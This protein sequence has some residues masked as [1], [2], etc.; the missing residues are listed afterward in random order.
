MAP[1]DVA[2]F[3]ID[4]PVNLAQVT[5]IVLT[6]KPLA[7][8]RVKAVFNARLARFRRFRQRVVERGFPIASPCWEDMP[9]FAIEQQLH[10]VALPAPHD[11]TAL[12]DLI[13]DLAA[14]PL[15]RERPLW[16]AHVVDGIDG[17]SALIIRIHHCLG[18]GTGMMAVVRHLFDATR[19]P[20]VAPPAAAAPASA[21]TARTDGAI[22]FGL[23][24]IATAA[25]DSLARLGAGFDAVMHPQQ[26]LAKAAMIV[27]GVAMLATELL[28]APD[29]KSPLKGKFGMKKR[30]AWSEPVALDDVKAIGVPLGA[31][32]NDVLVAAMTGALRTYL[33]GRD[34]D[35]D[36]TTVRAMVPVDLRPPERVGELGN[37]FGLVILDLP[38]R[39]RSPSQRL[40][41]TKARM[42]ALKRSPEAPAILTLFNLFG[43]GPK[44][45]EDFAVDL[46]GSK[47]SLVMTNVAGPRKTLYLAGVPID[48]LMFW[49]PHPGRQLGMGV[50]ILSYRG[51]ASLAVI[52]DARLVPDP[53]TIARGFNREFARMLA[54]ARRRGARAKTAAASAHA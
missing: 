23:D 14:T 12:A 50:S 52:A 48:R 9:D 25:R 17:G 47:A 4:G 18:D 6:R 11:Q 21:G 15:D 54:A 42:D 24:A 22:A 1:A 40:R 20:P 19:N 30:V 13:S 16:Q 3:H 44:A 33:Q 41:T 38:V 34:V 27:D 29:P 28:K 46:F 5:G 37:E 49:V 35:V 2:W 51:T 39:G 36:R 26:A 10:H 31:K 8:A 45:V 43:R 53:E 32:I 7:F